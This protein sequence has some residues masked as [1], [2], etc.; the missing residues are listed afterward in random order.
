MYTFGSLIGAVVV[1]I[2]LLNVLGGKS[3]PTSVATKGSTTT[4]TK[5]GATTTTAP[6]G[7]TTT[8]AAVATAP[9]T[10]NASELS[11]FGISGS[12]PRKTQ[13]SVPPPMCIDPTHTYVATVQTDVGQ[14]QIALDPKAAPKTVNNFVFLSLYHFYDGVVF[15]RVIPDFVVQ[16][17]SPD[18]SP[19]GG[20][21]YQFADELPQAGAYKV[22]SVAMANSGPNTNGSQFFVVVGSQGTALPPQYSLYGQVNTGMDIVQKIATDGS[23]SG[24]PTVQHKM[25]SVTIQET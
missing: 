9:S 23:Q 19:S 2:V 4:T 21:G 10:V 7:S 18:G 20:P 25:L 3:T 5:P 24:T 17:G 6:G 1:V 15:H 16:G 11:C 22:G 13:F 12:P 8:T 14:F